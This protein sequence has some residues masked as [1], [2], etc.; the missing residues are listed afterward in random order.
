LRYYLEKRGPMSEDVCRF[1]AAEMLLGLEEMHS[2]H[3]V[4]TDLKPENVLLDE[5]GHIC[6]SDFGLCVQLRKENNYLTQGERGT[7][8][9]IAP[10]ILAR[11]KYSL[12]PDVWTYGI[13]LYEL[14]HNH[15]PF[16]SKQDV[17]GL[18][19]NEKLSF[20]IGDLLANLLRRN[21]KK[22]IGCG[23][24][25]WEAVKKH[26]WFKPI[27][28]EVAKSKGL[29][30][31]FKP[32]PDVANCSPV[33]DLEDQLLSEQKNHQFTP[34]QQE[35]FKGFS[36]RV[37]LP[38]SP[39]SPPSSNIQEVALT[40]AKFSKAEEFASL[41]GAATQ[42]PG[43][44]KA[45]GLGNSRVNSKNASNITD[46]YVPLRSGKQQLPTIKSSSPTNA[47]TKSTDLSS[48][49][50]PATPSSDNKTKSNN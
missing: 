39:N 22:R 31:P 41:G 1:F 34:E 20:E 26:A 48:A 4:Y 6:I 25:A 23:P 29:K 47:S 2:H 46:K 38:L 28:W 9:Y 3:I 37:D 12:S 7:D 24:D 10:E 13:V 43:E 42:T 8:G 17:D 19:V 36:Y 33:F 15:L 16:Q 5:E 11:E 30:P 27:D 45:S 21:H 49:A 50:T 35:K 40:E 32:D 44:R 18:L 14:L